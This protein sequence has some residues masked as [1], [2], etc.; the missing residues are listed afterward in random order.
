MLDNKYIEMAIEFLNNGNLWL[1]F[2]LVVI[3]FYLLIALLTWSFRKPLKYLAS[4]SII[5][6]ILFVGIYLIGAFLPLSDGM[7]K[8]VKACLNPVL[9]IG[10]VCIVMGICMLV[11]EKV[12]KIILKNKSNNK[13]IELVN[14]KEKIMEE[15]ISDDNL[16]EI[17]SSEME[18]DNNK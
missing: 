1:Y 6:G 17:T 7:M 12:L 11:L 13:R 14:D 3:V 5:A 10:I 4:P 18:D 2:S 9:Q 16:E 15:E 8:I